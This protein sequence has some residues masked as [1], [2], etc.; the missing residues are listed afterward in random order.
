MKILIECSGIKPGH[1]GGVENFIYA[2]IRGFCS[3]FPQ[4]ELYINIDPGLQKDF[5]MVLPGAPVVYLEDF[6]GGKYQLIYKSSKL[7]RWLVNIMWRL[8]FTAIV[9]NFEIPRK[10]WCQECEKK[11]DIILYPYTR[12]TKQLHSSNKVV[13]VVHDLRHFIK[14]NNQEYLIDT[15]NKFQCHSII[16]S[17]PEP[18]S[19]LNNLFPDRKANTFMIPFT[20]ENIPS[21]PFQSPAIIPRLL[22]YTSSNGPDK[23]HENLIRALGHLKRNGVSPVLVICTGNQIPERAAILNELIRQED[24][25]E[26]IHFLDFVPREHV[27][28]LY[29][30]CSAVITTTKYEAFSGTIMEA[31]LY[32]KPVA[33]S[34]INCLKVVIDPLGIGVKYFDPDNPREIAESIIEV[35]DNKEKYSTYALK[36][37][38]IFSNITIEKTARQYREVLEWACNHNTKPQWYPFVPL[39]KIAR[40]AT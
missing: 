36:A 13:M 28:W 23:N 6:K 10:K 15:F 14:G 11:V 4:D 26:W 27:Q 31:F 1:H 21:E 30:V 3:A 8:N 2:L 18:F 32:G 7:I 17:W 19:H 40:N 37:R 5:E 25:K 20:F 12:I 29:Q 34:R 35:I 39:E 9:D 22:L 38:K 16:T 33:C 24:V